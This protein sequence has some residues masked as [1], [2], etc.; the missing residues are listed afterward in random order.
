[1]SRIWNEVKVILLHSNTEM[2]QY[3]PDWCSFYGDFK[4]EMNFS[5][6]L[7]CSAQILG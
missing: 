7:I 2:E 1:M 4:L 3:S 5:K 6:N